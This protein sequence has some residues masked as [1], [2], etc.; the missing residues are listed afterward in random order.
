MNEATSYN[1]DRF[2][3]IPPLLLRW[4][5]KHHRK[6]PWRTAAPNPYYTLVSEAMLQQTQVATVV[7]YFNRFV[8]A[9][10]DIHALAAADEQQV[11][12][13]W[14]GLGYYRRARNLHAAAKMVVGDFA[15]RVPDNVDDLLKLPG[16]GRYT[17][18]AIASIAYDTPAPILD[19]NVARVLARVEGIEQSI[20]ENKTKA[21]LWELADAAVPE[22]SAGDF[23]QALMEL[24]ALV[25]TPKQPSCDAC[26]LAG[27]CEA[28]SRGIV[29]QLPVRNAR[30]KPKPVD[31]HIVAIEKAGKYLIEQRPDTGLWS[32]MWQLPTWEHLP[33]AKASAANINAADIASWAKQHVG[34]SLCDINMQLQFD[35]A[36][37]HRAIRFT[38]WHAKVESGRLKADAGQW[39]NLDDLKN[40]PLANPQ[41]AAIKKLL[42][43]KKNPGLFS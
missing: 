5:G 7:A 8:E 41:K 6:L 40:L 36:T 16:V 18:G 35:H 4:Y 30:K 39:R 22:K 26:P 17:A 28:L 12:T 23:N 33:D 19:G 11:L 29:A 9:F 42:A 24:G 13:L 25:C 37:T 27:E 14:Q 38:L 1:L 21:R 2:E 31:H 3:R 15:G 43:A 20:D 10:P 32:R 34:L